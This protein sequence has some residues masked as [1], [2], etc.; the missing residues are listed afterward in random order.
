MTS[1]LWPKN[2]RSASVPLYWSRPMGLA[3]NTASPAKGSSSWSIEKLSRPRA[4]RAESA[5]MSSRSAKRAGE[6]AMV[7]PPCELLLPELLQLAVQVGDNRRVSG[8]LGVV[9]LGH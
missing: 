7:E 8:A 1:W 3:S 5:R 2:S 4:Y 6:S 9:A